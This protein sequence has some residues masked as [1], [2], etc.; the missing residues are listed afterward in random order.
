M[1]VVVTAGYPRK[2]F[3]DWFAR[4]TLNPSTST[5]PQTISVPAQ[6]T[7]FS[8]ATG[9]TATATGFLVNQFVLPTATAVEGQ[10][11]TLLCM[12]TGEYKVTFTGTATGAWVFDNA[13]DF[14][15]LQMLQGKWRIIAPSGATLATST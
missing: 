5:T 2:R 13:E 6:L 7:I 1:S 15:Q 4:E 14:L 9:G 8:T 12:G 10:I 3:N 11:K